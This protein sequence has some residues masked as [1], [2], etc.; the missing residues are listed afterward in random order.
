MKNAV[1]NNKRYSI[2][3]AKVY[4]IYM[5]LGSYFKSCQCI[6]P[7]E[8]GHLYLH[9]QEMPV[10]KQF[11]QEEQILRI[12]NEI[13][14]EFRRRIDELKC[15]VR[16]FQSEGDY[17][18]YFSTGFEGILAIVDMDGWCQIRCLE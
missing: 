5:M 14:P 6:N 18:V 7:C 2:Q 11:R 1:M 9:Y 15:A 3:L 13:H 12:A 10:Q 8:A 16:F 17:Y 4:I